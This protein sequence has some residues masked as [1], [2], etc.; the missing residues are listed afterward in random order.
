M[1]LWIVVLALALGLSSGMAAADIVAQFN[2]AFG[3]ALGEFALILLPSF[4]LAAALTR[5]DLG[6]EAAGRTVVFAAP[7]AGAGMICPDTAYAAL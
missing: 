3:R 6:S 5:N 1:A 7:A 2:A 4:I